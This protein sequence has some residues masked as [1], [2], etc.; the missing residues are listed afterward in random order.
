MNLSGRKE[1]LT[2]LIDSWAW[3]EYFR[4]SE[5]GKSVAEIINSDEEIIVSPVN[6]GEVY[7]TSLKK[8]GKKGAMQQIGLILNRCRVVDVN[9]DIVIKSAEIKSERK[10]GFADAIILATA[11]A[12]NAE[13]ITGDPHFK[14]L[15]NVRYL[16]P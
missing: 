12:E 2:E 15:E 16:G 13:I 3:I 5:A 10:W 6:I 14:G 8:I 1:L 4:G 11:V 9:T 7:Y